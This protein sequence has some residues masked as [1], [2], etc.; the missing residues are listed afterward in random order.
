MNLLSFFQPVQTPVSE[1]KYSVYMFFT[2]KEVSADIIK[3]KLNQFLNSTK[4]GYDENIK[5]VYLLI[6]GHE[7]YKSNV[8]LSNFLPITTGNNITIDQTILNSIE[9]QLYDFGENN[10]MEDQGRLLKNF[11]GYKKALINYKCLMDT[12]EYTLNSSGSSVQFNIIHAGSHESQTM[13]DLYQTMEPNNKQQLILMFYNEYKK[14]IKLDMIPTG[15]GNS[16]IVL[17]PSAT[18]SDNIV[19]TDTTDNTLSRRSRRSSSTQPIQPRSLLTPVE[20]NT[21]AAVHYEHTFPSESEKNS[22]I[23]KMEGQMKQIKPFDISSIGGKRFIA[24]MHHLKNNKEEYHV[25]ID[26]NS[27]LLKYD[28]DLHLTDR[29]NIGEGECRIPPSGKDGISNINT[30]YVNYIRGIHDFKM[31]KA[32]HP[33]DAVYGFGASKTE[34][35]SIPSQAKAP[36]RTFH[37][38]N[39]TS[40]YKYLIISPSV[41]AAT[42][43]DP[44]LKD[45]K[46]DGDWLTRCALKGFT[47]L[48]NNTYSVCKDATLG[49]NKNPDGSR[50]TNV[51]TPPNPILDKKLL[52]DLKWKGY[53]FYYIRA[54]RD[55]AEVIVPLYILGKTTNSTGTISND[56]LL[57]LIGNRSSGTNESLEGR[58]LL[59]KNILG[60]YTKS[61]LRGL[62]LLKNNLFLISTGYV[63]HDTYKYPECKFS[64]YFDNNYNLIMNFSLTFTISN[65]FYEQYKLDTHQWFI[66]NTKI[67]I[68]NDSWINTQAPSKDDITH[69]LDKHLTYDPTILIKNY[70]TNIVRSLSGSYVVGRAG[71]S[72][73][74]NIL[75]HA[76]ANIGSAITTPVQTG[77]GYKYEDNMNHLGIFNKIHFINSK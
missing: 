27:C 18:V 6:G 20:I 68:Q 29:V 31:N 42:Y 4:T 33:N 37:V 41:L 55:Y 25:A 47:M 46:E 24:Q 70:N 73:N 71:K 19:N 5:N 14:A 65:K 9:N 57:Y 67:N 15:D 77:H 45:Y 32:G 34:F 7:T 56:K 40:L 43:Y 54:L 62:N 8:D 30:C 3:H 17:P 26:G 52:W 51:E 38:T 23:E 16:D 75:S 64:G 21:S 12:Y 50:V 11:I 58:G 69:T 10:I 66:P 76:N 35:H 36:S 2:W 22:F 53:F 39:T 28:L 61:N 59:F 49:C 72:G 63:E 60:T 48:K 74:F 44:Y 13:F 1:P